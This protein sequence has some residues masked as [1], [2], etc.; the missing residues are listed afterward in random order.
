M[1]AL[2]LPLMWET[3][4]LATYLFIEVSYVPQKY[5]NMNKNAFMN[6]FWPTRELSQLSSKDMIYSIW[7][8]RK[9]IIFLKI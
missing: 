2:Q 6:H 4:Y 7:W 3:T 9:Q 1:F 8:S 5:V